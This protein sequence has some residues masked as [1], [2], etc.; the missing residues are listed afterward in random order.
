M[1]A[2]LLSLALVAGLEVQ[3]GRTEAGAEIS[4]IGPTKED[5]GICKRTRAKGTMGAAWL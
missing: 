1:L 2:H 4:S 3:V 5:G